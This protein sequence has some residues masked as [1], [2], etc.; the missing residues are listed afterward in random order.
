M[1]FYSMKHESVTTAILYSQVEIQLK[2][3]KYLV[4]KV[5]YNVDDEDQFNFIK[6]LY[7]TPNYLV[8]T[9]D[10]DPL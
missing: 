6:G 10:E 4:D 3:Q 9:T 5:L 1:L 7:I 2:R 8:D